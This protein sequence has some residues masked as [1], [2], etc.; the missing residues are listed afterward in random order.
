MTLTTLTGTLLLALSSLVPGFGLNPLDGDDPS[1]PSSVVRYA[2]PQAGLGERWKWATAEAGR[3][4]FSKGYWVGYSIT[5]TMGERSFIG[6]FH[7]DEKRNHPSLGEVVTGMR[8]DDLP[9]YPNGEF[10]EMSGFVTY[11]DEKK[12]EKLV[13]KEVGILYHVD[14]GSE[15][16][17]AKV[18]VSNLSLRVDLENQPLVWIGTASADESVALLETRFRDAADTEAKKDFVTAVGVHDESAKALEF[19][20]EVLT[21]SG[22]RELRGDAGFW[23]GQ[24]DRD[25]AR[26]ILKDAAWKDPDEDIREKCIFSLSQ[27][28]SE[29]SLDDLIALAR[30]HKDIETRKHA[31]FWLGQ[32][33]GEKAVG[34]LKDMAYNDADTDVQKSAMFALTQV[35]EDR[36]GGVEELIKI[37]HDHPNPEIRKNAIFWLGQSESPKA[38]EALVEMVK[39]R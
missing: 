7:S 2:G 17:V 34:T 38:L 1:G 5:K 27:M 15:G 24:T 11:D 22:D 20:K 28:S 19:L 14:G 9:P 32:T 35:D 25:E 21:G 6:S 39:G 29:A 33:A 4:N 37:A 26:V 12:P 8:T 30:G 10:G 36:G 13:K 18:R 16:T 23:L 31:T 3:Q